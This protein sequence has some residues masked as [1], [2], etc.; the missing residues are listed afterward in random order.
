MKKYLKIITSLLLVGCLY[1]STNSMIHYTLS[2]GRFGDQIIAYAK[3]FYIAKTYHCGLCFTPFKGS[4]LLCLHK[5]S[6]VV[7]QQACIDHATIVENDTIITPD[8]LICYHVTLSTKHKEL[9]SIEALF[10]CLQK[11]SDLKCTLQ[12]LL[13]PACPINK[14]E[15]PQDKVTVALH[16]RKPSGHDTP[17]QSVQT[18]EL[19][20]YKNVAPDMSKDLQNKACSDRRYPHKFPPDQYYID[21]IK[22]LSDRLA[23][24]QLYVYLFTDYHDPEELV[25]RYSQLLKNSSHITL[26]CHSKAQQKKMRFIDDYYNMAQA[27]CLIRAASN[28]SRAAQLLGNHALIMFPQKTCW[29]DDAVI[30]NKV[31]I[32][33]VESDD[34]FH[35]ETVDVFANL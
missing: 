26:T 21:Q 30:V 23:G 12:K 31:G 11:R 14:I 35:I 33:T 4:E 2:K 28:F 17:L 18:Y 20:D 9:D 24:Q 19:A 16:V 29:F 15:W 34:I 3:A 5:N 27:D 10:S 1:L 6:H 7:C 13:Q 22:R 32:L 8:R 25:Q